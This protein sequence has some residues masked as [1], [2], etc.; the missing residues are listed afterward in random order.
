[1]W[2]QILDVTDCGTKVNYG[3][4]K[5]RFVSPVKAGAKIRM[6]ATLASVTEVAGGW[7]L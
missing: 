7:N 6:S 2:S 5:V 4:D 1:M 3:L